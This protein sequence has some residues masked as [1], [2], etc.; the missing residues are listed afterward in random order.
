MAALD[1]RGF[2]PETTF[3]LHLLL[4]TYVHGLAVHLERG[5]QAEAATG[6]T[7]D[8]WVDS[9]GAAFGALVASGRYPV[10]AKVLGSFAD[11]GCDLDLDVLLELGLAVLLDGFAAFPGPA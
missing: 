2:E 10:F 7:D 4:Y 3:N 1:A 6:L 9:R 11:D 8:Q 5:A